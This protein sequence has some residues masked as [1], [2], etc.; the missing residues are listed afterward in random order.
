MNIGWAVTALQFGQKVRRAEW[1][2][3]ADAY[4]EAG[5]TSWEHLYLE[6]REGHA[7]AVM[8]RHGDGTASHFGMIDA[9]LLADDWELS[10]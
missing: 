8:V 3:L 6:E 7:P 5:G 1:G 2:M 9:H 10:E 4:R